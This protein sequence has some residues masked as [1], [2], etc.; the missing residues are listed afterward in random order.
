MELFNALG[1]MDGSFLPRFRGLMGRIR[2]EKESGLLLSPCNS[3][4][5]FGM[6]FS[7][8]AVFV[9]KED[10]ICHIIHST[11][12]RKISPLIRSCAYVIEAPAGTMK[13]IWNCMTKSE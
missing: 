12:K 7:I 4:H 8:E 13:E 5:M 10:R 9:D 3:I 2:L 6:K 1:E 11:G